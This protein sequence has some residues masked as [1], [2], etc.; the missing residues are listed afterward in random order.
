[1]TQTSFPIL[2][3]VEEFPFKNQISS[4]FLEEYWDSDGR[5]QTVIRRVGCRA[6]V[7]RAEKGEDV[8]E[9]IING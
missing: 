8:R 9:N 2:W 7:Q 4:R 5:T 1:M 6:T 3:K